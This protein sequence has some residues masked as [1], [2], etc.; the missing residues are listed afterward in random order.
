M[1]DTIAGISIAG[2][3]GSLVVIGLS[4]LFR[5]MGINPHAV[6]EI[7][8][9]IFL[10]RGLVRTPLGIVLGLV[11]TLVLCIITA[12][13]I[14]LLLRWTGRDLW[15]LKG[16]L[17]ANAFTFVNIALFMPLLGIA[18]SFRSNALAHIGALINM[19]VLGTLQA[20]FL[21]WWQKPGIRS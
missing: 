21:A 9:E 13:I 19:S 16:V 7:S 18:P 10:P 17:G 5:L 12:G 6:W 20:A 14:H 2:F 8:A 11:A 4:A 1:R 15:W 3:L